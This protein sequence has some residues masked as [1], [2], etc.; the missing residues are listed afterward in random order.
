MGEDN[1]ADYKSKNS[2]KS[3]RTRKDRDN[4]EKQ[5]AWLKFGASA[6]AFSAAA[7]RLVWIVTAWLKDRAFP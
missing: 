1:M 2:G 4:L 3:D 6:L 7:V 5:V